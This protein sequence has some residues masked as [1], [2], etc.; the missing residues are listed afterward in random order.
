MEIPVDIGLTALGVQLLGFM[1]PRLSAWPAFLAALM[2]TAVPPSI[3]KAQSYLITT[4]AG[5]AVPFTPAQARSVPLGPVSSVAA[6]AHGDVYL[7]TPGYVFQM[8]AAGILTRVAGTSSIGYSG[9][10]GLATNAQ[11]SVAG[12]QS[13]VA[14]DGSGNVYIA[15]FNNNVIRQVAAATGIIT[16]VA[17]TGT[18]GYSGDGGTATSAELNFPTSVAVDGFGDLYIA[19]SD[20]YRVR[21][22]AAATGVITTVAG[23]GSAGNDSGDGGPATSATLSFP[24]GVAVDGSGNLYIAGVGVIRK[25]AAAT[26]IIITVAG[27]GGIGYSGDGGPATA[28]QF[29]AV[30]LAVNGSGDIY[31]PDPFSNVI[32]KVTAATGIITTVAGDG[33]AGY[34]GDGGLATSA[35]LN[36]CQAVAVDGTGNLFIADASNFVIREV[37]AATGIITTVAGNGAATP[38]PSA[39]PATLTQL[40]APAAVAV[41]GTGNL[42]IADGGTS[43]LKL[44]LATGALSIVAGNGATGYTGDGGPATQASFNGAT[45]IAVDSSGNIYIADTGNNVIRKVT[46]ATGIITTVAGN[47]HLGYSGDGGTATSAELESPLAVAVDKSGNIYIADYTAVRKVAAATGV[48][49]TVAV[50]FILAATPAGIAVDGSGN[51]YFAYTLNGTDSAIQKIAAATGITTTVAVEFYGVTGLAVDASGNIYIADFLTN[52][53]SSTSTILK[54]MAAT[55]IV[56]TIAGQANVVGFSGDGGPAT[57]A[58]LS[59][60]TGVAVDGSGNV[61]ITDL[62]NQRIRLLVPEGI[63][64]LLSI[65][66]THASSFTFGQTGATYSVVVSNAANAGP[67]TGPVTVSES[68]PAGLTLQ[69]MSGAGWSCSANATCTRS[70]YL[71]GGSSY[72][73]ITVAV[74]VA[75]DGPTQAINQVTLTGSGAKTPATA[76]DATNILAAIAPGATVTTVS[77]ANGAAPVTADSIVSLYGVNIASA[78]IGATAGPP[79]PLPTSLG[80]VSATITDSSGKMFPISLIVVTPNQVNAVLPAGLATGEATVNL[81]SSTG[82]PLA[83]DVSL[84]T[85]APSLFTSDESGQGIAAAQEVIA[86]QDGS[87][88]FI[89]AIASC[90]SGGCTPIP[91]SLGSDTD[92]A[93]LEL[94]GTGI[95]GAG[96]AANV[97]VT[98]GGA[99]G[100]VMYAGAQGGGAANSYYGLDQVN[101]LLPRSLAGAGPV[102]VVLT[103][104]GQTANTVMV[105]I[106]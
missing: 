75:Q 10:G 16:T 71:R 55:G 62:Y 31:I 22:V 63:S 27:N 92:Q 28:A 102:N 105:D 68:V 41:D 94:F 58:E 42:Y 98:V 87:Q 7:A 25:V 15:D 79:A 38:S 11:L 100:T 82:V 56:T 97:T 4:V 83:G 5:G 69:S 43:I 81:L 32:R 8:N 70:D 54:V 21:K 17:G 85:T 33:A 76:S 84:V 40:A 48:I 6:G 73:A 47:G 64:P 57:S 104:G 30:N 35:R 19:D 36:D 12:Y 1:S 39:G 34:T 13:G 9:D 51:I 103:A 74:N 45:G 18:H 24:S 86:H 14:V 53:Q 66:K 95:R 3:C 93:V 80:G 77:A 49:T 60:P 101:V 88:T 78:V 29:G 89:G 23:N 46:A 20:N 91:I 50:P 61:Y 67:V 106:Q 72:P 26:G 59:D 65:T 2:A 96:G 37:A 52:F 99:A 90:G 44:V